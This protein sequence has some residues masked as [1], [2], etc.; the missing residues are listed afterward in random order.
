MGLTLRTFAVLPSG[1]IQRIGSTRLF[2]FYNGEAPCPFP[3]AAAQGALEVIEFICQ[4][5][6][7]TLQR[8]HSLVGSRYPVLPSGMVDKEEVLRRI[9]ARMNGAPTQAQ[10]TFNPT[11][12]QVN[13]C[14]AKL[15][16]PTPNVRQ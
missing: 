11:A 10:S 9:L 2:A 14:L 8:T 13:L 16:L 12:Q 15:G 7:R 5:E 6:G 1:N 3:E 4:A